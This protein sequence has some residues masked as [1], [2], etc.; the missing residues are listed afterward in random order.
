MN[1]GVY[2]IRNTQ[3]GFVY[4]GSSVNIVARLARHQRDL[5]NRRHA[6]WKLVRDFVRYGQEA[7]LF[8]VLESCSVD[9]L[10]LIEQKY[11]DVCVKAGISYNLRLEAERPTLHSD[12]KIKMSKAH[13]ERYKDAVAR[14]VTAK[15]VKEAYTEKHR[16]AHSSFMKEKWKDSEYRE[17]ALANLKLASRF[18][19]R[20]HSKETRLK[21]SLAH[22]AR[23]RKEPE[24]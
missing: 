4:I 19:G 15:A 7:F 24:E 3:S 10:R 2:M 11:I 1:S 16:C 14:A 8:S 22:L 18:K 17:K 13:T 9:E 23:N 20:K 21:M 6:N 12:T 5:K